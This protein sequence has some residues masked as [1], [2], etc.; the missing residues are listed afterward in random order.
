MK[1]FTIDAENNITAHA[2]RE[3]AGAAEA[4][5]RFSSEEELATLA[6]NWP[7]A[8]LIEIWNSLPG[9]EPVRKF[10]SRNVAARRIWAAIQGL[11]PAPATPA[12]TA[13]SQA[14]TKGRKTEKAAASGR[15]GTKTEQVLALLKQPSGATLKQLL[16]VTGWQAHSVRGF[17]SGQVA[18]KM[19]LRVKSFERD[20][21]RVYAVR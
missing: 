3:A 2:S 17:I 14:R 4:A 15:V 9:V 12:R 5:E 18:R 13:A 19:G 11:E 1:T 7:G 8:R 20:G 6:G 10:T 21:E 16:S